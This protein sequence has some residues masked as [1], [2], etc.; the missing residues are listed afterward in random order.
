MHAHRTFDSIVCVTFVSLLC[1]ASSSSTSTSSSWYSRVPNWKAYLSF[2][3]MG[4]MFHSQLLRIPYRAENKKITRNDATHTH[5]STTGVNIK[6]GYCVVLATTITTRH[7]STDNKSHLQHQPL[8][9]WCGIY[10]E[11]NMLNWQCAT[12]MLVTCGIAK[13]QWVPMTMTMDSIG[14][15]QMYTQSS[16]C[17]S[18][19]SNVRSGR[20]SN[21]F[22]GAQRRCVDVYNVIMTKLDKYLSIN[23]FNQFNLWENR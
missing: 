19:F 12:L 8:L 7:M 4:Y 6:F 11:V 9:F 15:A 2:I 13:W 18:V 23:T 20:P 14:Y 5:P 21:P 10:I 17:V 22:T 1:E 3:I 16:V